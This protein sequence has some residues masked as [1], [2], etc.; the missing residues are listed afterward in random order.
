M[1]MLRRLARG[2][3]RGRDYQGLAIQVSK[4]EAAGQ[5]AAERLDATMRSGLPLDEV[6]AAY[7]SVGAV[8]QE[9]LPAAP[10]L[11]PMRPASLSSQLSALRTRRQWYLMDAPPGALV[12]AA[13]RPRNRAP[14]GPHVAGLEADFAER[15]W[16]VDLKRAIDTAR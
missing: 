1:Q 16:G 10:A 8:V 13:V 15:P 11:D 14:L 5:L 2:K 7:H 12:P 6:R 9:P 3:R 4:A